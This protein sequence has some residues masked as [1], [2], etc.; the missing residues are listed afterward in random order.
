MKPSL[1]I[2]IVNWNAGRQL[3][4]CLNSIAL[5]EQGN[6]ALSRVV[7]VDNASAPGSLEGLEAAGA[8]TLTVSRTPH[9]RGVAAACNQARH[10]AAPIICC[11]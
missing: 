9:N 6:F 3:Y 7:V 4:D 10:E 5:A 11:S 2:V 8:V 1:D